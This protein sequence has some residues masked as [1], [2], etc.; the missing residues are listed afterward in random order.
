MRLFLILCLFSFNSLASLDKAKEVFNDLYYSDQIKSRECAQNTKLFL[1]KLYEAKIDLRQVSTL[2]I[3]NKGTH[4]ARMVKSFNSRWGQEVRSNQ[5]PRY[6]VNMSSWHYHVAAYYRGHVFDFSQA[7][8]PTV[9]KLYRYIQDM[10]LIRY[11]IPTL[12][13]Y[14]IYSPEDVLDVLKTYEVK[15][16]G[17]RD[18]LDNKTNS[19]NIVI[20]SL[21]ELYL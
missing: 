1:K 11:P 10:F 5:N 16:M 8:Q 20:K 19:R 6:S 7:K 13:K 4:F 2:V 12:S 21:Y 17:F 9:L 15:I 18:F 14:Q 3:T